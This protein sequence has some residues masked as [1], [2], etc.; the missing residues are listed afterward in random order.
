[1][2]GESLMVPFRALAEAA[3]GSVTCFAETRQV[4]YEDDSVELK[5]NV[6]SSKAL[7]TARR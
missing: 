6:G 3:G 2:E 5:F 7:L 4:Y 1:M